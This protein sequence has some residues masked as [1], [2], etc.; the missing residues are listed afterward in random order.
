ME[1]GQKNLEK[2]VYGHQNGTSSVRDCIEGCIE[3][4]VKN[5]TLLFFQLKIGNVQNSKLT[6]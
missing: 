6:H 5:I 2:K 4:G 1:D 3:L